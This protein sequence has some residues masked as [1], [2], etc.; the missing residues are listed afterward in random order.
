MARTPIGNIGTAI[1]Y[2]WLFPEVLRQLA[3]NGAEVL[4]RV[5][6]YM[7][8][9]GTMAPMDWWTLVNRSRAFENL[10]YVV[11][12]NQG[13]T[14]KNF[15]PFVF[16]GGSM[17]VDFDGRVL[18]QAEHG[19]GERIVVGPIDIAALRHARQTRTTHAFLKHL[20]PDAYDF[21][22]PGTFQGG[23]WKPAT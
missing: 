8:P 4:V 19:T 20:R 21:R 17:I 13:A 3:L 9:W 1:C 23:T 6:A 16:P 11:A 22:K 7:E 2:D 5:S 14:L 10:A 15:P 12:S 18:T